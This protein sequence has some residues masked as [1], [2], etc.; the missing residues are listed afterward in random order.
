MQKYYNALFTVLI[1]V[2]LSFTGCDKDEKATG[3]N[4]SNMAAEEWNSTVD[5]GTG[6]GSWNFSM[7]SDSSVLV[8]G[9]WIY[10]IDLYGT[11]YEI[12]CPFTDGQTTISGSSL[13]FTSSGTAKFTAN[14]NQTSPFTLNVDG[15]TDNGQ[16]SGT[17]TI[18]FT[19]QGWPSQLAGNWTGTRASG[20]GITQ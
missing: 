10:N 13:S 7:K 1:L 20:S 15:T 16:G 14:A 19:A 4:T 11:T 6:S 3:A 5:E 8:D 18:S 12:K 2:A 9:E 17:Y